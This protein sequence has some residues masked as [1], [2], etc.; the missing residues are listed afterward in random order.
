MVGS[1]QVARIEENHLE[2]VDYFLA[3]TGDGKNKTDSG[4]MA[5]ITCLAEA[6][7]V[8]SQS[9]SHACIQQTAVPHIL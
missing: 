3:A 5:K 8:P 1:V 6:A 2:R 9:W 7:G 4:M